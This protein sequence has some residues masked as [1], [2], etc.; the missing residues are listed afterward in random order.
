MAAFSR[1]CFTKNLEEN[2]KLILLLIAIICGFA[3]GIGLRETGLQNDPRNV[4]YVSFIG[5]IF[6]NMLK[7]VILPL[8]ISSLI[9][10]LAQMDSQTSGHIGLRAVIYYLTTTVLAVILGIVLVVTIR[11]GEFA[12]SQIEDP[13]SLKAP[14]EAAEPI[15]TPDTFLDLIRNMFP[16]NI[17]QATIQSYRTKLEAP[18]NVTS[19]ANETMNSTAATTIMTTITTTLADI[20]ATIASTSA[21]AKIA[22]DYYTYIVKYKWTDGTNILGVV[23]FT[24]VFGITISKAGPKAKPLADLFEAINEVT[25]RIVGLI[26]WIAP[27]GVT[28]LIAGQLL[29]VKDLTAMISQL[30]MYFV[31]VVTGLLIHGI[32]LLPLIFFII[33]RRNPYSFIAGAG[34][35]LITGFGTS[36]SSATLPVTIQCCEE[37]NK[38]DTR[39]SRFVLPIGATINMDG[40]ALYEAVAAIYVAQTQGQEI[41]F[42]QI[43][44]VSITA[45]AAAIG[46]A[47]VP[48]AGLVTLVMVMEAVGLD[49]KFVGAIMAVD[50]LLD[51][52]RTTVNILGD[53]IGTGIV[54]HLCKNYL[55]NLDQQAALTSEKTEIAVVGGAGGLHESPTVETEMMQYQDKPNLRKRNSGHSESEQL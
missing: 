6:L 41:S 12:G 14:G 18:M 1:K 33:T 46:A 5:S 2:V 28:F 11:P 17:I 4:M 30:G 55:A 47:G 25:M 26:M 29:E 34:K 27:L 39:V 7:V 54:N 50:W 35:A 36:S 8:I 20:N 32:I 19:T 15:T 24:I 40:T 22:P 52:V 45:T 21:P 53:V 31:T 38:V 48:Q 44:A 43:V 9:T 51:R 10:G 3:L 23:V 42:A 37:N 13:D 16:P 49:A